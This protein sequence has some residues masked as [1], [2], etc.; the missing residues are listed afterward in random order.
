M[1]PIDLETLRQ[2]IACVLSENT[3]CVQHRQIQVSLEGLYAK[4]ASGQVSGPIQQKLMTI[5]KA[6]QA[7][8]LF[9]ANQHVAALSSQ[10]WEKQ[11][12]DWILSLRRVFSKR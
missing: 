6:V 9:A 8:D 12:K 11:H 2:G 3:S 4:L 1:S 5:A 10:H 7:Q